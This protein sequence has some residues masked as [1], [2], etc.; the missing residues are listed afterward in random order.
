MKLSF[1]FIFWLATLISFGQLIKVQ[2]IRQANPITKEVYTFPKVIVSN[3]LSATK[4]INNKLRDDV[5]G[6]SGNT[7]D[8]NVFDSIW[9]TNYR[10]ENITNLSFKV[11]EANASLISLSIS[12]E[13]CGA[14]CEAFNYYFTFNAKTGNRLTLDSLFTHQGLTTFV[15]ILNDDKRRK[16]NN[17]LR[18]LNR[19]LTLPRVKTASTE[20]ERLSEMLSMYTDC[21]EKK[22]DIQF[23][24]DI[25]FT[26]KNGI[27]TVYIDRCSA[28]YNMAFDELWTFIYKASLKNS[29][30]LLSTYGLSL[31]KQ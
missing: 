8:A 9:R 4:K 18:Q 6:T 3:S 16:L 21:L 31:I 26:I 27:I 25:E 28:H 30:K 11:S 13:S 19:S 12:G 15:K 23:I 2:T 14:Y 1:L 24:S 20:K 10:M 7:M 22:V 17:K 29:K 5:L